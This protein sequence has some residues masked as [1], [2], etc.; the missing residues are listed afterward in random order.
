MSSCTQLVKSGRNSSKWFTSPCS[1][2]RWRF[3]RLIESSNISG[4]ERIIV[5][6]SRA[7]SSRR[8]IASCRR[9]VSSRPRNGVPVASFPPV[10]S[11]GAGCPGTHRADDRGRRR[12]DAQ[13]CARPG[14]HARGNP[15]AIR[16]PEDS[17]GDQRGDA[18]APDQGGYGIGSASGA[19]GG[20][21]GQAGGDPINAERSQTGLRLQKGYEGGSD[22]AGKSEVD[23]ATADVKNEVAK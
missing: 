8:S 23:R 17:G 22:F 13:D 19:K 1:T 14:V 12:G 5:S 2:N 7:S 18:T 20:P 3:S 21:G 4:A 16:R 6:S 10:G 9:L 11:R 15:H